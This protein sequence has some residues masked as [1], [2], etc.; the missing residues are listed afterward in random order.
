MFSRQFWLRGGAREKLC[1][2]TGTDRRPTDRLATRQRRSK[3]H[4][5]Q[6]MLITASCRQPSSKCT[7]SSFQIAKG[8]SFER[9]TNR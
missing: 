1:A 8:W 4:S 7:A 6:S 5:V 9:F 3:R 2:N